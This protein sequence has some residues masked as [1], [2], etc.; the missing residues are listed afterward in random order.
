[1]KK[2][3]TLIAALVYLP[4]IS[5]SQEQYPHVNIKDVPIPKVQD[6][7]RMIYRMGHIAIAYDRDGDGKEDLIFGYMVDTSEEET[8][9]GRNYLEFVRLSQ[10]TLVSI[11]GKNFL[12]DYGNEE[13]S[14]GSYPP[15]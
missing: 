4:I 12:I 15:L 1:M 14:E 5:F 11:D 10:A 9:D 13:L 2:L 3:T 8:E 6:F 7:I